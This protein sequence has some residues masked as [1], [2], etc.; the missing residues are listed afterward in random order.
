[1]S[2]TGTQARPFAV[3]LLLLAAACAPASRGAPQL[4]VRPLN[5]MSFN[6]RYGTAPD[7]ENAW[8]LRRALTFRA[9]R[10]AAP[11]VL[12]VQ[13]ALRF[14]LD[15]IRAELPRYDEVGVARDDGARRGE[16][17][18]ILYDTTRLELLD[19]GTFWLSDT[20]DVP[21]SMSWGNRYVRIVTW[22]R[23]RDRLAGTDFITFNTHWDHE[24][25]PARERSAAL[26]LERIA[27]H[28]SKVPVILTGDFNA[29]DH[30]PAFR[31]LLDARR[32]DGKPLLRDTFRLA[33]PGVEPGGTFHAFTG[34]R[35][36]DRIDAILVSPH[37]HVLGADVVLLTENGRY[38]SDHYP[39]TATLRLA[40]GASGG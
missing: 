22:A 33:H 29:G 26:L 30:N 35:S 28:G 34:D 40:G 21:G 1:M 16:Y 9:I 18:A 5:V 36:G 25:Q 10:E 7:G 15:E 11:A 4:P 38:P 32:G 14:Q 6:I 2:R 37:W 39:V 31:A 13:E 3:A 19:S 20:P 12:G 27:A 17:S 23:L 8:P 24:S